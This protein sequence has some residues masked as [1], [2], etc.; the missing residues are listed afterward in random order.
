MPPDAA[1]ASEKCPFLIAG[2]SWPNGGGIHRLGGGLKEL[3]RKALGTVGLLD[4]VRRVRRKLRPRSERPS[5]EEK[6]EILLKYQAR[7]KTTIFVETGTFLGDTTAALVP[8][9][10]RLY[11]I[12][13]SEE[14]HARAKKRFA[15]EPKVSLAL[16]DSGDVLPAILK[17]ID[18]PALFWL[19]GHYSA[20]FD[21]HGEVFTTPKGKLET[22]IMAELKLVLASRFPHVILIDDA[23]DFN[24]TH[25]YP[26]YEEVHR[27][28]KAQRPEYQVTM[29]RD[30]IRAVPRR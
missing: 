5:D 23:R 8:T 28:I 12:E 22:P 4:P 9:S 29:S 10:K 19:D 6:R 17:E 15:A 7:F 2:L 26:T 16:G 25:D 24:G 21:Y 18:E 14:L 3:L 1:L 11:T 27:F 30:I 20:T 13:L